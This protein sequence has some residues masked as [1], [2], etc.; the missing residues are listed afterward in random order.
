MEPT[1][2]TIQEIDRAIHKIIAKYPVGK[3]AVL[4]DIHLEIRQETGDFL[5]YDDDDQELNRCVVEQWINRKEEDFYDLVTPI[6]YAR[7]DALRPEIDKMSILHP[8][9]FVLVDGDHETLCDIYLVDEEQQ[10]LSGELMP[11]LERDL[12]SF[13][14]AL[15]EE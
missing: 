14:K 2:Q 6:L 7:L 9:S 15:F 10:I 13:M 11:D 5:A 8:F 12:N 4:T 1:Q 3:D